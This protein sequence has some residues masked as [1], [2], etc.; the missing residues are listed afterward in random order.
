MQNCKLRPEL[1]IKYSVKSIFNI[2]MPSCKNLFNYHV[3]YSHS[4]RAY[5]D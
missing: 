2:P 4:V 3:K 5:K 1:K